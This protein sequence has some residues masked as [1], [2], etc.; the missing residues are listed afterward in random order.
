[1]S[2][3]MP[4]GNIHQAPLFRADIICSRI[5]FGGSRLHYLSNP[6]DRQTLLETAYSCGINYFDVAP[7]YGHGL[8]ERTLGQFLKRHAA[9]REKLV[10]ATKWGLPTAAWTD[11]IPERGLRYALVGE[12]MRRK[13]LGNPTAPTLT[14]ALVRQ[15]VEASLRRLNTSYIDILWMHEPEPHRLPDPAALFETLHDLCASGKV[16]FVGVAGYP[17]HVE[18]TAQIFDHMT[19]FDLPIL[20][21]CDE[22]SWTPDVV[23]DVTFGAILQGPQSRS[24]PKPDGATAGDRLGKA[25]GRRG[26]GVVLISTT[27]PEN[28]KVLAKQ[29]TVS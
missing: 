28:I 25:L 16:R 3:S 9:E 1:M 11:R 29:A 8:A 7:L 27:K 20:R 2:E 6:G 23:P 4:S 22:Q 13:L 14:S 17:A 19:S 24:T 12:L 18:P 21:Q 26:Q 10:I 5:G 15:S